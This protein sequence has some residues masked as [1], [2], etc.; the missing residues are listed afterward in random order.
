MSSLGFPT[1]MV[2]CIVGIKR[3]LA[4]IINELSKTITAMNDPW[5]VATSIYTVLI[6]ATFIPVARAIFRRVKLHPAGDAF[7]ESPHFSTENKKLL[8]QHYSRILGTLGFWKNQAAKFESFHHYCLFWTIPSSVVIPILTQSVSSDNASKILLTIVS[9]MTAILLAF[10]RGF[11]VEEKIKGFRHGE[12]EFYDL[13]RRLLDRPEAFGDNEQAQIKAYFTEVESIRRFV[14]NTET[15]NFST[16][17]ET[18][19]KIEQ[20]TNKT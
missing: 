18:R 11:K 5:I 8:E 14:R 13:Y 6:I 3:S 2:A 17:D 20:L 19:K 15:N 16:L 9:A 1:S 10:H 12:S 4:L 7:A